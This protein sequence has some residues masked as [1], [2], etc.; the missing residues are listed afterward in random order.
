MKLDFEKCA[1]E[2]RA[3][4]VA[5][6]RAQ[7]LNPDKLGSYRGILDGETG[8]FAHPNR[9]DRAGAN[10]YLDDRYL[11]LPTLLVHRVATGEQVTYVCEET[12]Y[13]RIYLAEHGDEGE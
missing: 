2:M 1:A 4:A 6:C 13:T 5:Y 8:V 9:L 7:G 10:I 3:A 12:A 11:P